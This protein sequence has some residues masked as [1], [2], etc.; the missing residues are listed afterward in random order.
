MQNWAYEMVKREIIKCN[1]ASETS[2]HV[3]M[4]LIPN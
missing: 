2:S 3:W 4:T 1:N